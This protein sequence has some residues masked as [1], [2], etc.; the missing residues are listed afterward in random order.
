MK[1]ESPILVAIIAGAALIVACW[2][3]KHFFSDAARWER[4]RRRSNSPIASKRSQP[5][6]RL[7]ANLKKKKKR[8]R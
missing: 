8:E 6:V 3:A 7:L 2:V 1:F 4:R 5:S